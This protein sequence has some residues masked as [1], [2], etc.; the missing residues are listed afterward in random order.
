M[1]TSEGTEGAEVI[2]SEEELAVAAEPFVAGSV[3]V[4]KRVEMDHVEEE[5]FRDIEHVDGL[6][7]VAVDD[8]DSGEV[9]TLPDGSV[10]IPLLEERLVV[11]K[12][13]VVRERVIVRKR[14]VTETE[15]VQAELRRERVDIE[16]AEQVD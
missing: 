2:R 7:R 5:Y 15:R 14:T 3:R 11:T 10:S 12:Q 9:E 16:G 8:G 4:R 6:E 1:S 13:I